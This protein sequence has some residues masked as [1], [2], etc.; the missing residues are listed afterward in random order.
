LGSLV[1]S[2][3]IVVGIA[4]VVAVLMAILPIGIGFRAALENTGQPDPVIELAA[5]MGLDGH[6]WL[7]RL[8]ERARSQAVRSLR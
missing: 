4:G 3:V 8:E 6:A 7:D 2:S 5:A 1:G